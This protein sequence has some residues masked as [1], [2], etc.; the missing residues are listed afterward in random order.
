MTLYSFIKF[1]DFVATYAFLFMAL[2]KW[3]TFFKPSSLG[4]LLVKHDSW[5]II[6]LA[7]T[8]LMR[9]CVE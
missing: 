4:D 7:S 2:Y 3:T 5:V 9:L 1:L 8:S 6:A